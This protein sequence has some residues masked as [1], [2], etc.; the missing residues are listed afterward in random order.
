V[1]TPIIAERVITA[2]DIIT[3]RAKQSSK[4]VTLDHGSS[5]SFQR[6]FHQSTFGISKQI[7]VAQCLTEPHLSI[8]E[9]SCDN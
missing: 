2:G 3:A 4:V 5:V 9:R 7:N 8:R 1:F 6:F